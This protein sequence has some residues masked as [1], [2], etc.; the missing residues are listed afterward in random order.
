MVSGEDVMEILIQ[1]AATVLRLLLAERP[2]QVGKIRLIER[3][4]AGEKTVASGSEVG[5][6][7]DE[8]SDD[9]DM[10]SWIVDLKSEWVFDLL[11]QA[12]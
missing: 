7:E 3:S 1:G 11:F 2:D 12:I 5:S 9:D 6:E 10:D 4:G 8:E